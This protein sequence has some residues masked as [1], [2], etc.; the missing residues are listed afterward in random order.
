M[1][2]HDGHRQRSKEEFLARPDSFPDHKLLEILLFYSVPQKDTNPLSHALLQ[3]F[4][5]LSGVLDALPDELCKVPG[6]G[7]HTAALLKLVKELSG[8]YLTS[9]TDLEDR[10][11]C[12]A[13]ALRLLRPYFF[14]ARNERV[15][16]L[17]MDGKGKCLAI[18]QV[19]EGNV[20]AAEVTTRCVVEAALA[21]NAVQ[22]ILAHNHVSGLALPSAEDKSTTLYLSKV[23]G[24]VGIELVD[25]FIFV[26]DDMVS[27]R[28]SGFLFQQK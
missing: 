8:R 17:C 3:R 21:V 27:M 18:R 10:V 1:G 11:T 24:T 25:H 28:D 6:V 26:D 19:S 4:G 14:G 5:S 16:V 9:R 12:S 23:L 15:C 2:I 13:D 7:A 22:V 20:N